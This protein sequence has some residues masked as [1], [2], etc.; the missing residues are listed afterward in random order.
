[1]IEG[2]T[3]ISLFEESEFSYSLPLNYENA[4]RVGV[5]VVQFQKQSRRLFYQVIAKAPSIIP[6]EKKS[7]MKT[8]SEKTLVLVVITQIIY[9]Q[10][11]SDGEKVLLANYPLS[12]TS[13]F[14]PL[15][16]A[17][18]IDVLLFFNGHL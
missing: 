4:E 2:L 8:I 17:Q 13:H 6:E 15:F 9:R 16:L 7:V 18:S 12:C 1:M 3:S 5:I 11:L 10:P 14:A